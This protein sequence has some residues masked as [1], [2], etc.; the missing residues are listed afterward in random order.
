MSFHRPSLP[1][2][3]VES[4]TQLVGGARLV[5]WCAERLPS[6]IRVISPEELVWRVR[7]EHDPPQT[8]RLLSQF[9]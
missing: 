4:I 1:A 3:L 7:M 9:H 5:A 8:K 6:G 2:W